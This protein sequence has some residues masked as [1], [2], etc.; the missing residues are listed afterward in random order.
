[1][2]FSRR[3]TLELGLAAFAGFGATTFMPFTARAQG[4]GDSYK[5]DGGEILISPVSHASFVMSAPGMVIYNDPVGGKAP[6]EGQPAAG[7]ILITH[8][9]Q[10]HFDPETLAVEKHVVLD[11][12]ENQRVVSAYYATPYWQSRKGRA[13]F[14]LI[15]YKQVFGRMPD[16]VRFEYEWDEV[17]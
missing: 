5:T 6:Y 4:K 1:M 10:D 16:I 13:Y 8:E 12:A 2:Q 7:L 17:K 15:T 9:H 11:N 14:N 3:D